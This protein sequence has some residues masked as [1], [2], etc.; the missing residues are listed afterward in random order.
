[1]RF[2]VLALVL[3]SCVPVPVMP[4]PDGVGNCASAT[5]NLK[6]L[7]GCG[8]DMT[9]FESNCNDAAD[10]EASLGVRLPVGCLTAAPDCREA[11]LCE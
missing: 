4:P 8:E 3:A 6:K 7:G 10:A 1:M 2:I 5:E 9:T 11:S